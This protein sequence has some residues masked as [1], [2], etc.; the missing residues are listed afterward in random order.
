M[1]KVYLPS[2]FECFIQVAAVDGSVL[3][4]FEVDD[5]KKAQCLETLFEFEFVRL[6]CDFIQG[7]KKKAE[8]PVASFK[9]DIYTVRCD[10]DE[11]NV[12]SQKEESLL[13]HSFHRQSRTIDLII[14]H[15][16]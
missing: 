2:V 10:A 14:S 8:L 1:C 15:Q 16:D 12:Y 9:I 11:I 6:D 3:L 13:A 4:R 5:L 7:I